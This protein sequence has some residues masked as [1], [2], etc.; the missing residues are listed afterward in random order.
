MNR[1]KIKTGAHRGFHFILFLSE[2]VY[3]KSLIRLISLYF[4]RSVRTFNASFITNFP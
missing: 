2:S 3:F 4:C 1:N